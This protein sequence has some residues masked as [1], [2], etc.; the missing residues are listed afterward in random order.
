MLYESLSQPIVFAILSI[1][2]FFS[3]F[4]ID[5]K[6]IFLSFFKKNIFFYHF[7]TFFSI[8]LLFFIYF[9]INLKFNYGEFRFF[10]IFGFILS[11]F[12]QRF[13]SHNFLAKPILKCYNK[14][15]DKKNEK[16][17]LEKL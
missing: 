12:I 10:T 14:V 1:S 9:S 13:L 2:G 6:N 11:F 7:F 15:K 8:F 16:N 17:Q 3:A 5:F 4:L